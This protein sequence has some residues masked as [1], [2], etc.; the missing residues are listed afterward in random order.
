MSIAHKVIEEAKT[1][2]LVTLYFACCFGIVLLLKQLFLAQ[3]QIEFRGLSAALMGALIVGKVVV[4]LEKAPIGKWIGD[5]AVVVEMVAR[6]I[7][8]TLGA[9]VAMLVEHAFQARHEYGGFASAL[10]EVFRHRDTNH[11]WA[12]VICVSL[13]FLAYNT[14]AVVWRFLGKD[15]LVRLF[16]KTKS[17]E[18]GEHI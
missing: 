4:V 17:V 10:A 14:G 9:M 1:M 2:G 12:S 18:L 7:V 6:T 8:Y 5:R 11:V 16:F 3:Y 15:E 13:S